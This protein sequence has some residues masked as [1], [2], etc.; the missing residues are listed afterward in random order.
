MLFPLVY[1]PVG[2]EFVDASWGPFG[3]LFRSS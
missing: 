3:A 1:A 2:W